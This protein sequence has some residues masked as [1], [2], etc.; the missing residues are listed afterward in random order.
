MSLAR[1][2]MGVYK[3]W[4]G[5]RPGQTRMR[6]VLANAKTRAE[7]V[8]GEVIRCIPTGC[9]SSWCAEGQIYGRLGWD[10]LQHLLVGVE[11]GA[12]AGNDQTTTFT[13]ICNGWC[14]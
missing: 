13:C 10:R 2:L 14:R 7:F 9:T 5:Y 8:P 6:H 11:N 12:G 4:M 3:S 1:A